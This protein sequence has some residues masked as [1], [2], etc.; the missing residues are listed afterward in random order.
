[1]KKVISLFLSLLL[2]VISVPNFTFA[3]ESENYPLIVVPGFSASY[4]YAVEDNGNERQLWGSFEGMN[5]TE[6]ILANITRLGIGLGGTV[7]GMPELLAKT[8]SNGI[9]EILG[10]I[11]CNPDG[12]PV[13]K[14]VTYPNDPSITNYEYLIEEKGSMH[15]AEIEIMSDISDYYGDKGFENIYSFQTDFRLSIVDAIENLRNYVDAVLEYTG[16]EKVDIFAVSYGGQ[17]AASYLNVYGYENKIH[18]AVLT[19]P[20]IGGAAL[21]YDIMNENVCFDEETLFY[22]LE[23]G[24][25]LEEDINWLMKAHSLGFLDELLNLVVKDGIKDLIGFWGSIW[26]FIPA[27]HYE[28]L[29][30]RFLDSKENKLLIEKSDKFHYDI[31]PLMSQKLQECIENGINIYIVAGYDNP[32]VTGMQ[33]QSDGIIHINAATGAVC[34]P[35]GLRYSDGFKGQFLTCN[36]KSHN[37]MSPNMAVDASSGYLP[38]Q[39]WY[40]SGLFHGMTWKDEY[41]ISLCKKLLFTDELLSVHSDCDYPQFRYSTNLC[42]AVDFSFDNVPYATVSDNCKSLTVTNISEKYKIKLISISAFGEDITFELPYCTILEPSES[43]SLAINCDL[44]KSSY[45]TVDICVNFASLG[46]ISMQGER[47]LSFLLDNGVAPAYNSEEPYTDVLQ[48]TFFDNYFG[49]CIKKLL[50]KTGFYDYIKMIVNCFLGLF[51]IKFV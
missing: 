1:M 18:N 15:A 5:I 13:V 29:K 41:T 4:L 27:E 34:A 30:L 7:L 50:I 28:E 47:T 21:A 49:S 17:I 38:E 22:F 33:E 10:D 6:V 43:I 35:Y 20:A 40:V 48:T 26:D 14:T 36:D 46:N 19:V 25:M 32:A 45:K 51:L 12:T 9:V 3:K 31:L 23:N 37:H 16:A 11:A 39:T 8:L 42:F 24:M 44:S 2:I